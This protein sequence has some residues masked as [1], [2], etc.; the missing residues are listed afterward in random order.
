M[1]MHFETITPRINPQWE[2]FPR[3]CILGKIPQ[4]LPT[5]SLRCGVLRSTRFLTL[6]H[7]PAPIPWTAHCLSWGSPL[8]AVTQSTRLNLWSHFIHLQE[9]SLRK[10]TSSSPW[11]QHQQYEDNLLGS[12]LTWSFSLHTHTHTPSPI[13]SLLVTKSHPVW[14]CL[15]SEGLNKLI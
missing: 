5:T 1:N 12:W 6:D 14:W 10:D 2:S 4:G 8:S 11:N 15:I 7:L 3:M 13:S 9:G